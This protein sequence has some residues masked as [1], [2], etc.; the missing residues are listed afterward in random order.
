MSG[1]F[2]LWSSVFYAYP[3]DVVS[4]LPMSIPRQLWCD[5]GVLITAQASWVPA[6]SV[7]C[8]WRGW[9]AGPLGGGGIAHCVGP[10]PPHTLTPFTVDLIPVYG[11]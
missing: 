1:F 3:D 11:V 6:V 8:T 5:L 2:Y 10:A 9:L 4:F 7:L